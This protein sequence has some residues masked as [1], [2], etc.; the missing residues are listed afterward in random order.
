M[1]KFAARIGLSIAVAATCL[2]AP[3]LVARGLGLEGGWSLRPS[4][5]ACQRRSAT[6]L[7]EFIPSC[8]GN[9]RT[10]PVTINAEGF[11]SPE[12]REDDSRRIL[13]LGD[14]CT[15]GWRV[16]AHET[17]PAV[18]QRL[19]DESQPAPGYQVINTG[20]PGYTAYQG[21]V[22]LSDRGLALEPYIVTVA[23]GFNGLFKSGDVEEQV[24][25]TA[26]NLPM[27]ELDD[28]LMDH[29][30]LYAWGRWKTRPQR[31]APT[32]GYR[33]PPEKYGANLRAIVALARDDGAKILFISF[34]REMRTPPAWALRAVLEEVASELSVP[35]LR[36]D[37]PVID[38]VHPTPEGY[39]ILASDLF[40]LIKD[41]GWLD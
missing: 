16:K 24:A 12:I 3:E 17:Y 27:L 13:M 28:M 10:T 40:E 1:S 15:F 2:L 14:S 5:A 37:G 9:V 39:R 29:S 35:L 18:F 19:L 36:Y 20:H 21:K 23:F 4:V 31:D 11:R 38:I 7:R 33:E 34:W 6:L 26:A 30:R 41:R 32:G 22:L 25:S 8:V